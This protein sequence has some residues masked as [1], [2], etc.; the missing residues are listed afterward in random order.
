MNLSSSATSFTSNRPPEKPRSSP[1][2]AQA[3][4]QFNLK[5]SRLQ[6]R[7]D[8]LALQRQH[9]EHALMHPP[10]RLAADE[11]LQGLDTHC[12]LAQGQRPLGGEAAPSEAFQ[13]FRRIVFRAVD[14]PQILGSPAFYGRLD[15][16]LLA[17]NHE[18]H[19]LL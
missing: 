5:R 13:V 1:I 12:K 9:A 11:T 17:A 16:A 15:Q 7:I 2:G 6:S 8:W 10:E 3:S 4:Q 19:R 18:F 14:D